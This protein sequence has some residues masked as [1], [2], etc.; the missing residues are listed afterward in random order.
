MQV[1]FLQRRL[2]QVFEAIDHL[3]GLRVQLDGAGSLTW[4]AKPSPRA[5]HRYG[6]PGFG[7]PR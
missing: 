1:E 2:R 3:A 6:S 4:V 5:G 7:S